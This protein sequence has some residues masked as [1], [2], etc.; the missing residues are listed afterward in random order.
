MVF[1]L[2]VKRSAIA[3]VE[4]TMSIGDWPR[5]ERPREKLLAQGAGTLSDAELLAIFLRTGVRGL[6]AVDLA[7]QLMADFGSVSRLMRASQDEFVSRPGLGAAKYAQLMAVRELS[8]RA[9]LDEMKQGDVLDGP[10]RVRDYLRLSIGARDVEV[11]VA[12]LLSA[13]NHVIAVREVFHGTLMEARVYPREIVRFSLL[14]NASGVIVA[15][16]HPSGVPEPS[17]EDIKLTEVLKRSLELVD[18]RLLDH[19]VVTAERSVSF[20]ERGWL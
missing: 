5:A 13:R 17:V 11:F 3:K 15:H 16:N 19:F 8:G 7:R 4:R 10:D 12:I 18:I 20:N 14:N 9:L 1:W 2:M 6:S